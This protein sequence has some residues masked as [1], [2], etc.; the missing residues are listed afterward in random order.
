MDSPIEF[1]TQRPHT[2]SDGERQEFHAVIRHTRTGLIAGPDRVPSSLTHGQ[3]QPAIAEHPVYQD[4]LVRA[5]R[6]TSYAPH[7]FT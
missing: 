1:S 5:R 2:L 4:L 7:C 6:L 3:P